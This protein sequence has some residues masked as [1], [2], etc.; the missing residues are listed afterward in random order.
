MD[1]FFE[2]NGKWFSFNYYLVYLGLFVILLYLFVY[3][4]IILFIF[5]MFMFIDLCDKGK[6]FV[7]GF[8]IV[9]NGGCI[10]CLVGFY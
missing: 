4:F 7:D 10:L 2:I 8:D 3:L 6:Y 5:F 9:D 1:D